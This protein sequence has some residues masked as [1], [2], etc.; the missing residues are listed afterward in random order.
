MSIAYPQY[1]FD[2]TGVATT[3]K[4]VETQSIRSRGTFDQ[5]FILPRVGPFYAQG[6]KFRLYPQDANVNNPSLGRDLVEGEDYSFGYHFM[7]AS[8]TIGLPVYG[9]INFYDRTLEGQLRMEYQTLGGEWVLDDKTYNEQLLNTTVNPRIASWEQV[10]ELPAVFP[11]VNHSFDIDDFVGMSEVVDELD[12]IEKAIL[13]KNEGGLDDHVKNKN[14][15]HD[16]TKEQIG[17]GQ[18]DNFPTATVKE[19]TDGTANNRFMTP[20]RVKQLIDQ[21]ATTGLT[22]HLNDKNNPHEVNKTQVG[23][24]NV[25]N[26][27]LA[28]EPEAEAGASNARYMTPLR[29]RQAIEAIALS[30]IND[31]ISDKNNPHGTTKAHVGLSQVVNIGIATDDAALAGV[32][33]SGVITP[34]ILAHVLSQ[35]TGMGLQSHLKDFNNPHGTTK[36]QVGLG[37]VQNF[38]LSSEKESREGTVNNKYMTPLQVRYAIN[39]LVGDSSNAHVTDYSNP[40]RVTAAQVGTYSEVQ[41][42]DMFATKLGFDDT[43]ANANRVYNM[44]QAELQAWIA[45]LTASN[46]L[47]FDGRT[48]AQAAAEILQG[49]ASDTAKFDGKTYAEVKADMSSAVAGGSIQSDVPSIP[50]VTNTVGDESVPPVNWLRLGTVKSTASDTSADITLIITGGRD[51]E[52]LLTPKHQTILVEIGTVYDTVNGDTNS[53]NLMVLKGASVKYITFGDKPLVIGVVSAGTGAD[54]VLEVWAKS[55]GTRNSLTITELSYRKFK[56]DDYKQPQ[57]VKDLIVKEPTGIVY[58]PIVNDDGTEI[59]AIKK[60]QERKDNP[61]GVTKEQVGLKNVDNFST[62]SSA[63]AIKGTASDQFMTPASTAAKVDDSIGVLCDELI[64]VIDESAALFD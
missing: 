53:P 47:K 33:D 17:L 45:T 51:D 2:P 18:V 22:K 40:H 25:Q 34:R 7:Y 28:S 38:G 61:H 12:A 30:V 3:N 55:E 13:S 11:I 42:D 64:K 46:S 8:H 31:H 20:L 43:A 24:S 5:Y 44:S 32:D 26:L 9:A 50:L 23:L 27:A 62:A 37:S 57:A 52:S 63:E 36:D 15:P 54:A 14:N 1:P 6:A 21:V 60:F 48:F 19:A 41:L 49:K 10:V 29:T 59:A 35:T 4:V 39:S 56:A 58:L 16:V